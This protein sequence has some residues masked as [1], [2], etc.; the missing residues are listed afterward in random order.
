MKIAFL[1]DTVG[2]VRAGSLVGHGDKF[3]NK[4]WK[5]GKKVLTIM[6]GVS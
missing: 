5:D 1:L 3:V 2:R 4:P 6:I